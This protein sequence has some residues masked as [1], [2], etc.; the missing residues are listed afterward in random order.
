MYET[1]KKTLSQFKDKESSKPEKRE[2]LLLAVY[3]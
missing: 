2:D 1:L 3:S